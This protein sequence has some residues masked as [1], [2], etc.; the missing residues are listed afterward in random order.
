MSIRRFYTYY[1][2]YHDNASGV[3]VVFPYVGLMGIDFGSFRRPSVAFTLTWELRG[4]R[5]FGL[6]D[7]KSGSLFTP[8]T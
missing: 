2:C 8:Y 7:V 6:H 4:R 1:R 3:G 5:T